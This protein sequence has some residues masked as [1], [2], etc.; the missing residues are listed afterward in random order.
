MR[1]LPMMLSA[2][3]AVFVL[4]AEPSFARVEGPWCFHMA[5][6]RA[7]VFSKCDMPS[8]EACRREMQGI[9]QSYCTENPYYWWN[10]RSE[11]PR[12]RV[13]RAHKQ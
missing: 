4:G 9:G 1:T 3:A 8:Y 2:A 7:G 10:A 12:K 11:P 13:K 5:M 6:G